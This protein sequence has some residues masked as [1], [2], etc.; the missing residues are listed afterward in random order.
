MEGVLHVYIRL[1][2]IIIPY[3]GYVEANLTI[4]DLLSL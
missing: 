4:L 2:G 3:K 1:E